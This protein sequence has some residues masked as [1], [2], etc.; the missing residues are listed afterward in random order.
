MPNTTRSAVI[1]GA[2]SGMG[3]AHA[4]LLAARGYHVHLADIAPLDAVVEAIRADGGLATAHRLDVTSADAWN[5]LTEHL[6]SSFESRL[7][8]LVNNAGIVARN[9]ILDT[10]DAEWRRTLGVN[11]DGAFF[12]MRAIAPLLVENG[13][14]SIVNISSAGGLVGYHSA[15]YGASKWA[16]RGLTKTAAAEFAAS[17]IRCNSVHPGLIETPLLKGAEPFIESHLRSIPAG[18]A[19]R[20]DEVS[21]VVAFLLSEESEY[22]NGAEI[23]VDGAFVSNG[24]YYRV[25]AEAE[26]A[27]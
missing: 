22:I 7:W 12:G 13:G 2:A 24:L 9:G 18:R 21:R 27:R 14:G 3:R 15:A 25:K 17:G 8:G 26:A 6:R 10:D 11:L 4:E 20:P 16:L 23:S 19:G 1:T 5:E